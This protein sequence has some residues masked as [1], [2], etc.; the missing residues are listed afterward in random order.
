MKK[1]KIIK[2]DFGKNSRENGITIIALVITIIV[3]IILATITINAVFGDNGL[4]KQAEYAKDLS[5]NSTE[6]EYGEMNRLFDD[7]AN[8]LEDDEDIPIEEEPYLDE[9]L[10]V[11]PEVSEG[12]IPVKW[13][14]SS[15]EKTDIYDE[16]WYDYGNKEWANVVLG[17]STFNEEGILDE[18]KPYSMLVWIPRYAYQITSQ[19]HQSGNTG[20]N[21]NI[22]FIDEDNKGRDGTV[23]STSYPDYS[24][25]NGMN[26]YVVHP[27]FN[28]GG[29]HLAGF[30]VGKFETSNTDG[31]GDNSSTSNDINLIVQI[32]SGVKSW[33][34]ISVS[35][36]FTVCTELN[37]SRNIYGLNANDNIVDPHMMKNSE[38]G[39]VA[40]LSQ[41]V[42]YGKGEEIWIN[43]NSNY[44]TGQAGENV[45]ANSTTTTYSYN[46]LN[47]Q[48][49][50]TS[51]NVTGVYDMSG[52]ANEYTAAYINNG[53][54]ELKNYGLNLIN[55]DEKYREV[56]N[57]NTID[58]ANNNYNITIPSNGFY[59]DAIFETSNNGIGSSGWYSD[60]TY[61]PY[62]NNPF[63][64]RG[65][66]VVGKSD[67]GIFDFD[68]LLWGAY[69]NGGFR[70]VIPVF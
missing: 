31:Y 8:M 66:N 68:C 56:Y 60:Y 27:A 1:K 69:T 44:I 45:N 54:Q 43:P 63:F 52:G 30:W 12:M 18:S 55:A 65:G 26:D 49:A 11:P 37:K 42:I 23:Y 10:A 36:I 57:M 34:G 33:R 51:G 48:E 28:Y 39:A 38:W 59:G 47:G 58:E 40:Y 46:T 24:A 61:Y 62:S 6:S 15:W 32:K 25:G 16:E 3:L 9:S 64:A 22:V 4:I 19:Y 2:E 7:Y 41:N 35:N 13:N 67:A 50:S 5:S 53:N 21:I 29:I 14:G 17:D 20:G 70:I